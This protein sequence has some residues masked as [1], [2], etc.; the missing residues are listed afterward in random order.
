MARKSLLGGCSPVAET[1][2]Y[3]F[4]VAVLVLPRGLVIICDMQIAR[5]K[6]RP[7]SSC[8]VLNNG[9]MRL[10]VKFVD[11]DH[12]DLR[13]EIDLA[14]R[15]IE[16]GTND[17]HPASS[18]LSLLSLLFSLSLSLKQLLHYNQTRL[19]SFSRFLLSGLLTTYHV[20]SVSTT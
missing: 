11:S 8:L 9:S 7:I 5:P 6:L 15:L 1:G 17:Q 2:V 3:T 12:F 14:P 19:L 20:Q 13:M 18:T 10:H 4:Q 16:T